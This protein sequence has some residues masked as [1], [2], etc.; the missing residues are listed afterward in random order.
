MGEWEHNTSI[1]YGRRGRGGGRNTIM[2]CGRSVHC[3]TNYVIL[4]LP[5]LNLIG[6]F[7]QNVSFKIFLANNL[8]L[9]CC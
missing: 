8:M 7:L 1:R 3:D 6:C 4:I 9:K 2:G 5:L